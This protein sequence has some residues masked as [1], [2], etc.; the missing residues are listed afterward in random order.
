M[1][2]NQNQNSSAPNKEQNPK[3]WA[4]ASAPSV[5]AKV[6]DRYP[7]KRGFI[8]NFFWRWCFRHLCTIRFKAE[9][10]SNIRKISLMSLPQI[11]K[12]TL[13]ECDCPLLTENT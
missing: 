2:V 11:I 7:M 5:N 3:L 10:L 9:G 8:G 12:P 6:K 4:K 1:N 13:T